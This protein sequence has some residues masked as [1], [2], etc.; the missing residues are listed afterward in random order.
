MIQEKK[1]MEVISRAGHKLKIWLIR[2]FYQ[3]GRYAKSSAS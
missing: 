1:P 3:E 2:V